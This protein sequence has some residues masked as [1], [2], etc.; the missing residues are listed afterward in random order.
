MGVGEEMWAD[1]VLVFGKEGAEG[2][3]FQQWAAGHGS[4]EGYRR[5]GAKRH[6]RTGHF[7]IYLL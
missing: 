7:F 3:Q 1:P 5:C 4:L 6:T 2:L